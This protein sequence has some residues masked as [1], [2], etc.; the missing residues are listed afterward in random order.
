MIQIG[1]SAEDKGLTYFKNGDYEKAVQYYESM[2]KTKDSKD[3]VHFGLG[4]SLLQ[5]KDIISAES[6]L[7]NASISENKLLK[8]KAHYNLGSLYFQQK[9][10]EESISHFRKSLELNPHDLDAK[11]N[12]ELVQQMTQQNNQDCQDNNENS[13]DNKKE[14]KQNNSSQ[15]QSKEKNQEDESKKEENQKNQQNQ[16][17]N[18]ESNSKKSDNQEENK[19]QSEKKNTPKL[20]KEDQESGEPEQAPKEPKEVPADTS[21]NKMNAQAILNA[22][23]DKEKVNKRRQMVRKAKSRKMEKD[24]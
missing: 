1:F 23:K 13:E 24:W 16:S 9:K 4:A 12:Y 3:E 5:S 11:W 19:E 14:E 8:S 17:Q 7:K 22:L 2:L 20:E 18:K 15:D 10:M 6:A 21:K